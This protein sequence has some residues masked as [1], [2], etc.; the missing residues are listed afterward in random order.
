[1]ISE[2]IWHNLKAEH[3]FT[4]FAY[5][6]SLFVDE[7]TAE[8]REIVTARSAENFHSKHN[9][10]SYEEIGL[11]KTKNIIFKHFIHIKKQVIYHGFF[12]KTLDMRSGIL[13]AGVH[14][15]PADIW[16][17]LCGRHSTN[18]IPKTVAYTIQRSRFSE[19]GLSNK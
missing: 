7:L 2:I 5:E 17:L 16:R 13:V 4:R 6:K 8:R 3:K 15:S 18:Y 12:L 11:A 19:R 14:I 9:S 1:M 10:F